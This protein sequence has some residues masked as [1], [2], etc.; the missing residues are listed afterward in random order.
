MERSFQ[1]KIGIVCLIASIIFIGIQFYLNFV[2]GIDSWY[3]VKIA[4]QKPRISLLFTLAFIISLFLTLG[5]KKF[6]ILFSMFFISF[7]FFINEI[8]DYLFYIL[9]ILIL[10]K[11]NKKL[12]FI[13]SVGVA[14]LYAFIHNFWVSPSIYVE[15]NRNFLTILMPFP[16]YLLTFHN[17]HYLYLIT[18]LLLTIIF[19]V[20]K[21]TVTALF[22]LVFLYIEKEDVK[23]PPILLIF[24]IS[25]GFFSMLKDYFFQYTVS[26]ESEKYCSGIIC[27][28][29]YDWTG[30]Y[31]AYKGYIVNVTGYGV[32]C[33]MGNECLR[34]LSLISK[35]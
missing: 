26:I 17:K 5:S 32:N 28:P 2:Y 4:Y 6:A 13:Y 8:D 21:F 11:L 14:I 15:S 27:N 20:P 29:K 24:F 7:R 25:F 19:P 18:T 34:N 33:C 12:G 22:P 9:N 31:L 30:H 3:W 1:E 16:F 23:F 10:T 35:S